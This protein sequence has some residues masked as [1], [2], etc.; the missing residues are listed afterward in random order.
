MDRPW[1]APYWAKHNP[2]AKGVNAH[3]FYPVV[4]PIK[5]RFRFH[6]FLKLFSLAFHCYRMVEGHHDNNSFLLSLIIYLILEGDIILFLL[7]LAPR[8]SPTSEHHFLFRKPTGCGSE[9]TEWN[10]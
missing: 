1:T 2:G 9:E 5:V 3:V 8:N 6:A 10:Y 7:N 4:E